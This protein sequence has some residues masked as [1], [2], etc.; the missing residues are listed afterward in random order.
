LMVRVYPD[1]DLALLANILQ[2]L[3][4]PACEMA[5]GEIGVDCKWRANKPSP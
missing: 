2:A 1:T 3:K 5:S 4:A